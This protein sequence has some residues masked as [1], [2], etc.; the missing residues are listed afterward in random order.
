[1]TCYIIVRVLKKQ[2]IQLGLCLKEIFGSPEVY[3]TVKAPAQLG[4]GYTL[5]SQW[6]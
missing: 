1:M 4:L 3:V 2:E 6:E 5:N